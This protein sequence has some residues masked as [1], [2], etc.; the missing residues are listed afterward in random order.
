VFVTEQAFL[1]ESSDLSETELKLLGSDKHASLLHSSNTNEK[2]F[3]KLSVV[4]VV[5]Q[6]EL[7][8]KLYQEKQV[9]PGANVIKL[10]KFTTFCNK[11]DRLSLTSSSSLVQFLRVRPEPTRV[12]HLLDAPI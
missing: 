10:K 2:S 5:D 4:E 8:S 3:I 9:D 11:L 12:K 6:L 7:Q 1:V